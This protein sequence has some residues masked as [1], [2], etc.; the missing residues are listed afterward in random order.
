VPNTNVASAPSTNDDHDAASQ[1]GGTK[2]TDVA[3]HD[4]KVDQYLTLPGFTSW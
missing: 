1:L 3:S 4:Q 2:P